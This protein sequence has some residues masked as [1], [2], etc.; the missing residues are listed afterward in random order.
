VDIISAPLGKGPACGGAIVAA[1][2]VVIDYLINKARSFIFTTAPSPVMAAV[3]IAALELI[4]SE[5]Q[6]RTDLKK[7]T[8]YLS[9]EFAKIGL[10]VLPGATHIIP[11][12]LGSVEKAVTTSKKLL[13]NGYFCSAIRPP[14]VPAGTERLRISV[15]CEHT[16]K[17]LAGLCAVLKNIF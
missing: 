4:V 13:E 17:H 14:T 9:K 5:P 3:S 15:Q 10:N 11:V 16:Q 6:R 1:D 7:N 12:I 8:E 2:Q